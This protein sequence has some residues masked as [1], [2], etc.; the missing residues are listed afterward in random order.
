MRLRPRQGH[1]ARSS[2]DCGRISPMSRS[3]RFSIGVKQL[4]VG[5]FSPKGP[6]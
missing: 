5:T 2:G 1:D 4:F 6:R 3:D